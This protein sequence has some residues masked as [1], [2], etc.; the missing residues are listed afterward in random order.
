MRL[1]CPAI[2]ANTSAPEGNTPGSTRTY[3]GREASALAFPVFPV[4]R[5]LL[6]MVLHFL[7]LIYELQRVNLTRSVT[8]PTLVS[9]GAPGILP[10]CTVTDF[11]FPQRTYET[12]ITRHRHR[13]VTHYLAH[14]I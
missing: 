8:R 13:P 1:L 5:F 3:D 4:F 9:A 10:V 2:A 12:M 14:L 6:D 11:L 7:Y